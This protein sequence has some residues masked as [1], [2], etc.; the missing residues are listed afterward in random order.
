MDLPLHPILVHFP[1]A[2]L[3]VSVL[4]DLVGATLSRDSFREG[5][6]W[7]LGLGLTGGIAAAIAGGLAEDAAEKAGIAESLIERH[8]AFA[9]ATLVIM[10]VLLLSRLLDRKSTRLNSS[11]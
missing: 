7:L 3:F 2:L 6:L 5:A 10:A 4:F 8:E 1:I 9:Q 11:H